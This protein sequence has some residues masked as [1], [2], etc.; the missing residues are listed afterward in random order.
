MSMSVYRPRLAA[1]AAWV[2]LRAN[3]VPT[4]VLN[5]QV[6]RHLAG[7]EEPNA[8][9]VQAQLNRLWPGHTTAHRLVESPRQPRRLRWQTGPVVRTA[10]AEAAPV[11]YIPAV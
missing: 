7:I 2:D 3:T 1:L 11:D 9:R 5:W 6:A 8:H 4:S 10:C